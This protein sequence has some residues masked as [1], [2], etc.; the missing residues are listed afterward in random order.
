MSRLAKATLLELRLLARDPVTV[1]FTLALPVIVLYVLG[2]VF[3]NTPN[4]RV[5]RGVGAMNFYVPA[6]VA[7][8]VAS[9]GLVGLPVHLAGYRERGIL[10]RFRASDVPIWSIVGAQVVVTVLAG[11]LASLIVWMAAVV[12]YSVDLPKQPLLVVAAFLLGAVC[13]GFIGVLIGALLP[14]ARAAQG[15]GII[16]WFVMMMI[17]GSGPPPEV[18]GQTL[19]AISDVTPLKHVVVLIQDPWLGFGWNTNEALIVVAML[20]ASAALGFLILRYP[21]WL[22]LPRGLRRAARKGGQASPTRHAPA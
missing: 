19:R 12:S 15:A 16:L 2:Q 3:G 20:L 5:Y 17:G 13:F 14:T 8:A 22:S 9:M 18:L 6:Y 1:I 21:H 7:L 11:L 10:K 4:P